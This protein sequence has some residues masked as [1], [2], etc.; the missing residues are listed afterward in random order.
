MEIMKTQKRIEAI[1]V[2][3]RQI[4]ETKEMLKE[5]LENNPEYREAEEQAK[6]A[7]SKKKRL[8]DEISNSGS[9][10]ELL[11]KIKEDSEELVTLKEILSA[12]LTQVYTEQKVDEI[13]DAN[14]EVRKF[15]V[16]AKLLNKK[17]NY[18]YQ[19]EPEMRG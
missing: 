18:L 14:G 17:S 7:N 3:Q 1:E 13:Q 12:E 2:L 6:E 16:L 8:K 11:M 15:K 19:D 5:E 4:R 9:N 10:K